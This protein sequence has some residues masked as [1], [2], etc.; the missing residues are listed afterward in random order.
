MCFSAEASFAAGAALGVAGVISVKK[1]VRA[2]HVPF[3]AIP[4]IFGVQQICE[5]FTWLSFNGEPPGRWQP[6]AMY[7][8][9]FFAQV[10]WP[11]WVPLSVWLLEENKKRRKLLFAFFCVGLF[12]SCCLAYFLLSYPVS[13]KVRQ[14]HIRYELAFP[15]ISL[16]LGIL[17][18]I[19]T[20]TTCFLSSHA[21]VRWM[22]LAVLV[23]F[24]VS[25]LY[26]REELISVWCFFAAAI[27]GVILF[28]MI[29]IRNSQAALPK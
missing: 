20:A 8:F 15:N 17:Y 1:T 19:P 22:A 28:I 5:G 23:S 29:N 18:F 7:L 24:I 12:T 16:K 25:R 26:F 2:A 3:A 13:A 11:F 27:S 21:G 14:H 6:G 10:L 4:L 9:L